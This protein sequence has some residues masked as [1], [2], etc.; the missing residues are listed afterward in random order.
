MNWPTRP[1]GVRLKI[2]VFNQ[3]KKS[4]PATKSKRAT[5][6][7]QK[8]TQR[9]TKREWPRDN[10]PSERLQRRLLLIGSLS[11]WLAALFILFL[12]LFHSCAPFSSLR[13]LW[14]FERHSDAF[15]PAAHRW[16]S[17]AIKI[18][19]T[20]MRIFKILNRPGCSLK[21]KYRLS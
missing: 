3:Q 13:S 15:Q 12:L 16:S 19:T 17:A 6:Q 11:S 9:Q 7:Y 1:V 10:P 20:T 18:E 4:C 2:C 8:D 5:G 21:V 14:P